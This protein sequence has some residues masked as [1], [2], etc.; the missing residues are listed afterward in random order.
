LVAHEPPQS[1][2]V[3]VPFWVP[4]LQLVA[5]QAPVM[6]SF[7]MQSVLSTHFLFASHALHMLVGLPPQSTSVS[8][9]FWTPSVQVAARQ[10]TL[11]ECVAQSVPTPQALPTAHGLQ[12]PPQSTSL[13]LP[14]LIPS[15]QL[16]DWHFVL[17]TALWQSAATLQI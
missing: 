15:A 17:Q 2:S 4:S 12:V 6:Q 16:A 10:V 7:E 11:Q 3:S 9:P 13:S 5:W 1:T 14:F 8:R